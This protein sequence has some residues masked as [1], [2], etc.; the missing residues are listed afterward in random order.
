[1]K[2]DLDN[3][4]WKYAEYIDGTLTLMGWGDGVFLD[5]EELKKLLKWLI[6]VVIVEIEQ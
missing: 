5:N 2:I 4:G 3:G 6:D 1:M